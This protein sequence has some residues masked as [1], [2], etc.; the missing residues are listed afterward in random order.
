MRTSK[1]SKIYWHD[2]QVAER[3]KVLEQTE[4][5]VK[6]Q[7]AQHYQRLATETIEKMQSLVEEIRLQ[8]GSK[9]VLASH[10]Y[11]YDKY[12]DLINSLQQQL[13]E[14]GVY[15]DNLLTKS[16]T[17]L[18]IEHQAL[19]ND[20]LG[21]PGDVSTPDVKS[22][23]DSIW[24]GDKENYSNRIWHDKDLLMDALEKKLVDC[25]SAGWSMQEFKRQL[26]ETFNTSYF[27][28]DRIV[29]TEASYVWN[30]SAQD[31]YQQAGITKYKII[32]EPDACPECKKLAQQQFEVGKQVLPVHPF[33][34]CASIAILN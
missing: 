18:Y 19:L 26:M 22:S 23:I 8:G 3:A 32:A 31:K 15:Q 16:L 4:N 2:R 28:A 11:Q 9:N 14:L 29:T 12:Y 27:N 10:L 1:P 5:S 24:C 7:L 25:C 21:L 6:R 17:D 33:C 34:R 20:Q 13:Q 30:K